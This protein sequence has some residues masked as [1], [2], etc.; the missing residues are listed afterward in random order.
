VELVRV[1]ERMSGWVVMGPSTH[2]IRGE[3]R[4]AISGPRFS[5][6]GRG[7]GKDDIPYLCSPLRICF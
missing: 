1:S 5:Y 6:P 2:R 4:G 3:I 7:A